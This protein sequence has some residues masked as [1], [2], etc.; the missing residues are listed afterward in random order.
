MKKKN[1]RKVV[2]TGGSRGIGLAIAQKFSTR[3]FEV[4]ITGTK[5]SSSL[6]DRDYEYYCADFSSPQSVQDFSIVLRN[7]EPDIL[8]NNAGINVV[9]PFEEISLETF[10]KIQQVNVIAPFRLCQAVIGNMKKKQWGRIVNIASIWSKISKSGRA[11]YSTSKF[12]LDGMSVAI[13]AELSQYNILVNC[14]SP[15][16]IDTDLTRSTLGEEGMRK[17]ANEIPIKR[18]GNSTEIATLVTWLASE[19]NTYLTG[20]NIAIDGGFTRV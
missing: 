2:V 13:S 11:S 1:I 7:Y 10:I 19:E 20:Q 3:G 14:V 16:F 8:I 18:L 6:K 12:G 15:G 9:T 4:L 5:P 17:I